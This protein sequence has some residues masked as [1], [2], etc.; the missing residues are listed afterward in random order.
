MTSPENDPAL[1]GIGLLGQLQPTERLRKLVV[2]Y[3]VA[4]A[5]IEVA[6]RVHRTARARI[7]YT[8]AVPSTDDLF[9]PLQEALAR[10]LPS[11]GRRGVSIRSWRDK[12]ADGRVR[13]TKFTALHDATREHRLRHRGQ[14]IRVALEVDHDRIVISDNWQERARIVFVA[15]GTAGRDAILAFVE[16]VAAAQ[17]APTGPRLYFGTRWS[18]W[19][20]RDDLPPRPLDTVILPEEQ[21]ARIVDD[22]TRFLG[23]ADRYE[24]LGLPYHR[25]YLFHGPGGTGKTSLARA[26]ASHFGL[27]LY[28]I[29]LT[30]VDADTQLLHM[31][32]TITP[33]SMLLLEDVDV[34][35]GATTRDDD[36]KGITLAGLLNALD[37]V[38]T[39]QG[40]VTVMTT[41]RREKLDEA[42]LRRGRVDL[43]EEFVL[44]DA[45]LVKQM[46]YRFSATDIAVPKRPVVPADLVELVKLGVAPVG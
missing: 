10:R 21:K 13:S 11:R 3:V 24:Q 46:L 32:G 1:P 6:R 33:G 22:L 4:S 27:D 43:D 31:V 2:G 17:S 39:P 8:V 16:E 38:A 14:T 29:P 25:G 36:H 23:S 15:Y 37:G 5:A 44:F 35:H 45:E 41:N 12:A 42:L 28:F 34:L 18:E 19:Q 30:S 20:R 40:L 26:L 7:A 9:V